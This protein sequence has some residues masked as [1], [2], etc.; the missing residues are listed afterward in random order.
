MQHP[1]RGLGLPAAGGQRGAAGR[2]DGAGAFHAGSRFS[3]DGRWSG[4]E[5]GQAMSA[6]DSAAAS[7]A[8]SATARPRPR[9]RGRGSGRG[10]AR[11]PAVRSAVA[12]GAGRR[13]RRSGARRSSARA[14]VSSSIAEHPGQP[15]D[16]RGA[17]CGPPPA[18]RHVVLLHR[19]TTG[20]S[21]RDAGTASRLS[22]ETMRGLRC[23]ARSC[24]RSRRPGRRRG[25]AAGRGCGRRRGTGRCGAR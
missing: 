12:D 7:A 10:R 17:A 5:V 13:R 2:A 16:R 18:H 24:G 19:P 3:R 20:S 1:Q 6:T 14:A 8:P 22:S 23:T 25:T 11:R 21:R 4:H 9:S 15:V